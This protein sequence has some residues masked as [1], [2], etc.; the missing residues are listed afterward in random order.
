MEIIYSGKAAKQIKSICKSDHKSAE[1]IFQS[2]ERFAC[3]PQSPADLKIL[4]GKKA[5]FYH[6][7]VGNYRVVF[8]KDKEEMRIYE[9][10]HRQGAYK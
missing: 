4:K 2:I 10:K 5:I 6:L 9:I 8:E 7:R 1:L 3:D